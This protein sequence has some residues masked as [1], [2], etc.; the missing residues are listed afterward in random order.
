MR[1]PALFGVISILA[2][3]GGD[4]TSR[5]GC[6]IASM[7][8]PNSVIAQFGIPRQTLSVPPRDVPPRLVARIAGGGTYPAIVGRT[9]GPDSALVV[10]VEGTPPGSMALGFGVL[11]TAKDGTTRGVMLFEGLPV[12]AAPQIGTVS[13]GP[14]SAPLLGIEAD[15]AAYEDPACPL[16]PD[17]TLR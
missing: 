13:M 11:L 5:A 15:P 2:A 3:C 8:S 16:F 6:G 7:A 17:S 9:Q 4:G 14:M 10:G 1:Y 12:E